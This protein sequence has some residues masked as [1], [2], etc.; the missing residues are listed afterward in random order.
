MK[1]VLQQRGA[2]EEVRH[3]REKNQLRREIKHHFSA[4]VRFKIYTLSKR[5][6]QNIG[7]KIPDVSKRLA[8]RCVVV[9]YAQSR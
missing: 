4:A 1:G 6:G 9:P 3:R 2:Y 8:L 5:D 7:E